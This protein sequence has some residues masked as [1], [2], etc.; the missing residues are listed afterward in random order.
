MLVFL[1]AAA[2]AGIVAASFHLSESR[3][4]FMDLRDLNLPDRRCCSVAA[5]KWIAHS[6]W[7][8]DMTRRASTGLPPSMYAGAIL[9]IS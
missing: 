7:G 8:R 4:A 6:G 9:P 3:V 5:T 2:R 1:A